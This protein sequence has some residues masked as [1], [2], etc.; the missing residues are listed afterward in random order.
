MKQLGNELDYPYVCMGRKLGF[1]IEQV[2]VRLLCKDYLVLK[3]AIQPRR[4]GIRLR[5]LDFK[6]S[7]VSFCSYHLP[8]GLEF[9][10]DTW[11]LDEHL[12]LADVI[13]IARNSHAQLVYCQCVAIKS[14]KRPE[15]FQE[16]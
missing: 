16:V 14:Y 9:Q 4:N 11:R 12:V 7:L 8:I 13:G 2:K 1:K 6:R 15:V 10:R 3:P 5:E